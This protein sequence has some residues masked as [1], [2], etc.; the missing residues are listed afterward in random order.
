MGLPYL[1]PDIVRTELGAERSHQA[2]LTAAA[3]RARATIPAGCRSLVV[4]HAFITAARAAGQPNEPI[5][6]ASERDLRVGGIADATADAFAGFDYVALGHLHRAQQ[7]AGPGDTVVHYSGSPIAFS[8]SEEA[9]VKSVTVV[10]LDRTGPPLVRQIATPVPRPLVTLRG[11]LADLL[12]DPETTAHADS[13]VR[14]VLT[15]PR[16]P[17]H[18]LERLRS[19][20]PYV[21]DLAFEPAERSSGARRADPRLATER[22]PVAVASAFIEH[23]TDTPATPQEADLLR[24]AVERVRVAA[25]SR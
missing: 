22:D 6:S 13:W 16:R 24:A 18:S 5:T 3:E 23:V 7:V 19:L 8:F 2:V 25:G 9:H 14:V 12:D 4:A 1:E 21:A 17:E 11:T 10:D 15:D 20:L